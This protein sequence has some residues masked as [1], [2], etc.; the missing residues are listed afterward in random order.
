MRYDELSDF[1]ELIENHI[2][3]LGTT[4]EERDIYLTPVGQKPGLEILAYTVKSMTEELHIRHAGDLMV[5]LWALIAG[6]LANLLDFLLTKR[7]ANRHSAFMLFI[8]QS[9]FYDKIMSLAVMIVITGASF[10]L[11]AKYNYFVDTVLAL[12]TIVLIEEGRL[13]Y[14]GLLAVLKKKTKWGWVKR[15]I[16]AD[17]L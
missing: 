9:E 13:L 11:F 17:D 3:L 14:V 15:S 4:Q 5:L 16:Y 12:S 1:P 8:T 7:V 10:E 6:Y 2:V